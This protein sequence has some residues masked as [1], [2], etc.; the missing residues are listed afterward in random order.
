MVALSD[1]DV[2]FGAVRQYRHYNFSMWSVVVIVTVLGF[3]KSAQPNG[4]FSGLKA[5]TLFR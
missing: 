3:A 2:A 4:T 1:M 5:V